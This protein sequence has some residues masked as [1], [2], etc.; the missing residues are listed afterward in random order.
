MQKKYFAHREDLREKENTLSPENYQTYYYEH[1]HRINVYKTQ[2]D[3]IRKETKAANLSF[4][5]FKNYLIFL[6]N[7]LA[8]LEE[9]FPE[10]FE[11]A[12]VKFKKL[13]FEYFSELVKARELIPKFAEDL[14]LSDLIM[15][16]YYLSILFENKEIRSL[17]PILK[18]LLSQQI[19]SPKLSHIEKSQLYYIKMANKGLFSA[20]EED[21]IDKMRIDHLLF[22]TN[23]ISVHNA[24]IKTSLKKLGSLYEEEV[25]IQGLEIDF[26]INLIK[27]VNNKNDNQTGAENQINLQKESSNEEKIKE[28]SIQKIQNEDHTSNHIKLLEVQGNQHFFRNKRYFKGRNFIKKRILEDLGHQVVYLD[29]QDIE[30]KTPQ[31]ITNILARKLGIQQIKV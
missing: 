1:V 31:E 7:N 6:A 10:S 30:N 27:P 5:F 13:C 12:K 22:K 16:L 23:A 18:Q 29:T 3:K 14:R 11:S 2:F 24:S 28:A 4:D 19:I 25:V 17:L 20:E 15:V 9:R 21:F 26:K 8:Y